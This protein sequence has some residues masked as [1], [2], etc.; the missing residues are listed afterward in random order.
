MGRKTLQDEELKMNVLK[1]CWA[2]LDQIMSEKE[3]K[4]KA[5]TAPEMKARAEKNNDWI[6]KQKLEVSM[7]L[8]PRTVKTEV[9]ADVK[10]EALDQLASSIKLLATNDK[11]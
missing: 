7:A 3:R 4:I 8:A 10:I 1:K 2:F 9:R 6:K 11:N 5:S